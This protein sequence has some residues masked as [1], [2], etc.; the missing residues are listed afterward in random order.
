MFNNSVVLSANLAGISDK[1]EMEPDIIESFTGPAD[2]WQ[3]TGHN[4]GVGDCM[5]WF[6]EDRFYLFD[7]RGH[8]SKYGLG[9]HQWAHIS[10]KD[11]KTWDIHPMAIAIDSQWEGSI[12]A[13]F[14][15][16][17]QQPDGTLSVGHVNEMT[18]MK[19]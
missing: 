3:P 7:R 18:E 15:E 4:T 9:A 1:S 17:V 6:H 2:H 13:V 10:T 11:L 5:P 19:E 16:L 12:C 14:R 8:K